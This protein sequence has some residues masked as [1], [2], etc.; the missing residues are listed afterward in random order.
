MRVYQ[1]GIYSGI[2]DM[3]WIEIMFALLHG[4]V[5]QHI[6]AEYRRQEIAIVRGAWTLAPQPAGPHD[7]HNLFAHAMRAL[8]VRI[9]FSSKVPAFALAIISAFDADYNQVGLFGFS[10]VRHMFEPLVRIA[11]YAEG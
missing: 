6:D 5:I 10:T 4:N 11:L 8:Y 3:W 1:S 9:L 2:D 7:D